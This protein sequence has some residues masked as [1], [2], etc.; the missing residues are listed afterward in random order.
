[1]ACFGVLDWGLDVEVEIMLSRE[2]PYKERFVFGILIWLSL[3][4]TRLNVERVANGSTL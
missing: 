3:E 2:L 1:M 4:H